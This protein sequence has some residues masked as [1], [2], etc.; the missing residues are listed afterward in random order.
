EGAGEMRFFADVVAQFGHAFKQHVKATFDH[1]VHLRNEL[2][3]ANDGHRPM[4][5]RFRAACDEMLLDTLQD[6]RIPHHV[7]GGSLPERMEAIVELFGFPRVVAA[8]AAI[9]L[10][11]EEYTRLDMRLETQRARSA[12]A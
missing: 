8:D 7:V 3:L 6:L 10:A 12:R 4:S 1:F 2:P 11:R 9:A 5:E